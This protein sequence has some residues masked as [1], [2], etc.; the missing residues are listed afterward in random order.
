MNI[1]FAIFAA[2][3]AAAVA[4]SC[5]INHSRK[6]SNFSKRHWLAKALSLTA[7]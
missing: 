1:R 2:G 6:I 4:L 5:N 3:C 7:T